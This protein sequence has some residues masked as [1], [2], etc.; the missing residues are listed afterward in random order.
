MQT[1]ISDYPKKVRAAI[2]REARMMVPSPP[3][4]IRREAKR[5]GLTV[6]K[7]LA[8]ADSLFSGKNAVYRAGRDS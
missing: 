7:L 6:E 3:R 5:S 4:A 1:K 8:N 2:R